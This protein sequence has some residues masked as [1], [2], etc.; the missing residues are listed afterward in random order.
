MH[1]ACFCGHLAVVAALLKAGGDPHKRSKDG[2]TPL[3]SAQEEGHVPIVTLL[4]AHSASTKSATSSAIP[5]PAVPPGPPPPAYI[6]PGGGAT[7]FTPSD[8]KGGGAATKSKG[9]TTAGSVA[10]LDFTSGVIMEGD[11][12]K[13]RKNRMLKWRRKYYVLSRTYG[14]LFFWTGTRERVDGVIKKVRFETL[15]SVVHH[16]DKKDGKRFDL[17]VVT[18]RTMHL[19]ASTTQEAKLWVTTLHSVVGPSMAAIRIQS[20]WRRYRAQRM[21]RKLLAERSEAVARLANAAGGTAMN[22]HG[23]LLKTPGK[24]AASKTDGSSGSASKASGSPHIVH[25][26]IKSESKGTAVLL[27]TEGILVEGELKK[28]NSAG[29]GS[30][31][32]T[33]RTRYFVLHQ[34]DAAL[35]YFDTKAK[36]HAGVRPR[37]VPVLSFYS[38]KHVTDR[39]G[40]RTCAFELRVVSGRSFM[41]EARSVAVAENWVRFLNAVLP[42]QHVAALKIQRTYKRFKAVLLLKKLRA[43]AKLKQPSVAPGEFWRGDRACSTVLMRD[44]H[45]YP[46][47]VHRPCATCLSTNL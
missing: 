17:R 36:R 9:L 8:V 12:G 33:F 45:V 11:L 39:K 41:F 15:L 30:L 3:R 29:V 25:G 38:V 44:G 7:P 37:A 24:L 19:L 5:G 28:K 27:S 2:K 43:E 26:A 6:A 32:S 10:G 34:H 4:T 22:A 18:G 1:Y 31:L 46:L 14:A 47:R 13:K 42:K 16:P 23:G 35:Y 40:I 20:A 21:K